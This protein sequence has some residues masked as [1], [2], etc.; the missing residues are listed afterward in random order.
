LGS[1][2]T[3]YQPNL[4]FA[5]DAFIVDTVKIP[6]LEAQ[7]VTFKT[8][9]GFQLRMSRGSEFMGNNHLLRVDLVPAFGCA[10]P[11]MAGKGFGVA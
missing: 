5:K 2:G 3:I 9:S 7:D 11:F 1:A 6:K 4:F 10:N 8:K